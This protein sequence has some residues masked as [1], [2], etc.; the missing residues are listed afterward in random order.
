M[1][2]SSVLL[3]REIKQ[4]SSVASVPQNVNESELYI[5]TVSIKYLNFIIFSWFSG[6]SFFFFD[7]SIAFWTRNSIMFHYSQTHKK[8]QISFM[9]TTIFV[10]TVSRKSLTKWVGNL[11]R[12]HSNHVWHFSGTF[13]TPRSLWH[14]TFLNQ[15]F[16]DFYASKSE[17]TSTNV[18]F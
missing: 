11:I 2:L 5:F 14:F 18:P 15:C 1:F 3:Y 7:N 8:D 4:P 10:T 16:K 12:G 9:P 17:L 6:E 13:M